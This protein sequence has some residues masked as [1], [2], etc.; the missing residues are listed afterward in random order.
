M[1]DVLANVGISRSDIIQESQAL[2]TAEN[3]WFALRW[4]PKGT[5]HLYLVTSDFHMARA[6]YIAEE[7]LGHFYRTFENAYRD[8][9]RWPSHMKH[10]PRL[11]LHQSPVASFCGSDASLNRDDDPKADISYKSLGLRVMNELTWMGTREVPDSLFGPPVTGLMYI[12]PVQ[13]NVS[14]D[15]SQ[16]SR[17][18]LSVAQSM[19]VLKGLCQCKAPPEGQGPEIVYP[20]HFPLPSSVPADVPNWKEAISECERR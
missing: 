7:V 5:G 11:E 4:I 1:A 12:W 13:I 16:S 3:I 9:P 18:R 19:Y 20:L 14:S 10:Y 8:D 6:T 17:Y 2:S 15:P